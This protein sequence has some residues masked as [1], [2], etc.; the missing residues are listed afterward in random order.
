MCGIVGVIAPN[1]TPKWR[2]ETLRNLLYYSE[3]RGKDATGIAFINPDGKLSVIKNGMPAEKFIGSDEFTA[4]K[5]SLP[6]ITIGHTRGASRVRV[7]YAGKGEVMS[8]ADDNKNNHPFFSRETGIA[9]VHNGFMDDE[10]WRD[11]VG[12]PGGILR[13]CD[14]TTDSEIMLRVVETFAVKRGGEFWRNIKEA[15]FNVAGDYT[16]AFIK[17]DQ[18]DSLWL[19]RH[20]RTLFVAYIPGNNA[21]VFASTED[22]LERSLSEEKV[23][24]NFFNTKKLPDGLIVNTIGDDHLIQLDLLKARFGPNKRFNKFKF[25]SQKIEC[26]TKEYKWHRKLAELSSKKKSEEETRTPEGFGSFAVLSE[27]NA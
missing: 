2:F 22:I 1:A 14:G 13:P 27:E 20:G 12:E 17:E 16:L 11:T 10:M 7:N 4:V 15:C 18:P 9:M 6:A 19:V 5:D 8:S 3:V 24:F 23:I 21:M 25:V 26:A